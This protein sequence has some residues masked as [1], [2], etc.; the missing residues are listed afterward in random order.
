MNLARFELLKGSDGKIV[1][2]GTIELVEISEREALASP[3]DIHKV[4]SLE[5][6][7]HV[8]KSWNIRSFKGPS[9]RF[10]ASFLPASGQ[11][12]SRQADPTPSKTKVC[13]AREED[14]KRIYR[15]DED[16]VR[17]P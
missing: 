9:A 7:F 4:E 12:A 11:R 1:P 2:D 3:A 13:Q 16:K 17:T 8:A 15:Q 5:E 14:I 10:A 6:V